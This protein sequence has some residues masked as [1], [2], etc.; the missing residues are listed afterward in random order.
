MP[1]WA[2]ARPFAAAAEQ[3]GRDAAAQQLLELSCERS[4]LLGLIKAELHPAAAGLLKQIRE[5]GIAERHMGAH[6]HQA[7]SSDRR[8]FR[9]LQQHRWHAA[10]AIQQ[11]GRA[12]AEVLAP[13]GQLSEHLLSD[14]IQIIG[15]AGIEHSPL[16]RLQLCQGIGW[17]QPRNGSSRDRSCCF[18]LKPL[19]QI[20]AGI[21]KAPIAG[22]RRV[23]QRLPMQ[24]VHACCGGAPPLRKRWHQ[25]IGG[26]RPQ[27]RADHL[28][29]KRRVAAQG[30]I[31]ADT[32]S[33]GRSN[34]AS[35]G[36]RRWHRAVSCWRT[37]SGSKARLLVN[38]NSSG[39]GSAKPACRLA[40][41]K[42]NS[43]GQPR[44]VC[45]PVGS[46]SKTMILGLLAIA[47]H[48]G[49]GSTP[50]ARPA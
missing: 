5:L 32:T 36:L 26:K 48:A 12:L 41:L 8:Q 49:S 24:Q 23:M 1:R 15:A 30:G 40:V 44:T 29:L 6:Q 9:W 3:H 50:N 22:K 2:V 42:S 21:A 10:E 13:F 28:Q 34:C 17:L 14:H 31:A 47:W 19:G 45:E 46:S 43:R 39:E 16:P 20:A 25:Q 35:K 38:K 7:R 27:F 4:R 33:Q 18:V 37:C 11:A